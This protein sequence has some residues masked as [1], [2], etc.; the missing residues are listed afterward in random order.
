M[1]S[2]F[3]ARKKAIKRREWDFTVLQ[4]RYESQGRPRMPEFPGQA[5]VDRHASNGTRHKA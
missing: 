2:A 4:K 1:S 3:Q 5:Y